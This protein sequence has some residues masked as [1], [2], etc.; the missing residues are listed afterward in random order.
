V[1]VYEAVIRLS[2]YATIRVASP[3]PEMVKLE[4]EHRDPNQ[5]L[6]HVELSA[7]CIETEKIW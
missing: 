4:V 3:S 6:K 2:G 1:P 5:Y 7:E